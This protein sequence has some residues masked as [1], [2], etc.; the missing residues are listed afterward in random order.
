MGG[1]GWGASLQ[2][3][4]NRLDDT[5]E[6]AVDVGIPKSQH[7]ETIRLQNGVTLPV[8]SHPRLEGMLRPIDLDD[9][10]MREADEIQ[11]VPVQR[12]LP[13]EMIS[14]LSL[15]PEMDPKLHLLR[16]HLLAEF[17]CALIGHRAAPPPG[18]ALRAS[19]PSP[20]GGGIARAEAPLSGHSTTFGTTKKLSSAAGAFLR[21]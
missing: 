20:Q 17:A 8:A 9:E 7:L 6:I 16:R 15:R 3:R 19:P 11:N 10:T 5:F 2:F 1:A 12:N 4:E 18:S 13:A 14:V 21:I